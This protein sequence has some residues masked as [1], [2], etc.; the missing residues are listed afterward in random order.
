MGRVTDL[1][2][3]EAVETGRVP[4]RTERNA[5]AVNALAALR[6]TGIRPVRTQMP[7]LYGNVGTRLDGIG[8]CVRNGMTHIVIIE[9]KTTG[10]V[11]DATARIAQ[12]PAE[13]AHR[14]RPTTVPTTVRAA[15]FPNFTSW[16]L[17]TRNERRTT[18]R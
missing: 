4:A 5:L 16:D 10:R 1:C 7:V 9:L 11:R 3:Q 6:V 18:S 12:P 13:A 15:S 2:F 8:V 17:P 14:I